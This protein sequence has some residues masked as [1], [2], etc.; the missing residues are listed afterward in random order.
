M[1]SQA[2]RRLEDLAVRP[3][4]PLAEVDL[5][6]VTI[7]IPT[8]DGR[9]DLEVCLASLAAQAYPS[10]RVETIVVDNGSRDGTR[11]WLAA[12]HPRVRVLANAENLGFAVATNQGARAAD[13]ARVLVFVNNDV[14]TERSWLVELV[15]PILRGECAATSAKMLSW[16]GSRIDHAGGGSNLQGIAIAHGYG[17]PPGSQHAFARKCLFACGGAMAMDAAL[18]HRLGGFDEEFFA[19]YEDLDLGWRTWLAGE[20]VHYVPAAVCRHHHSKTS[21][22]FPPEMLRVL[23]ARNPL[24]TAF[25]NYDDQNLRRVLPALLGLHLGRTWVMARMGGARAFRVGGDSHR[26]WRPL[27]GL[28][29]RLRRS[30]GRA[31]IGRLAIA[32]LVAGNDLLGRLDHWVERRRAVQA[33]RARPD[34]EIFGLFLQPFWCVEDDP[35]YQRLQASLTELL[36]LEELFAGA[37]VAGPR[38][39]G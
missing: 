33:L 36:G 7:V 10:E 14:R 19:Y 29:D 8:L 22:R 30:H 38:P 12:H 4:P 16:D 18:F 1:D 35:G 31:R 3:G 9:Q 28:V 37:T 27:R 15:S 13:G 39:R 24:L 17:D 25:K 34:A 21:R 11:A 2:D 6:R 26:G 5:P 20:E 32:D 23:Q